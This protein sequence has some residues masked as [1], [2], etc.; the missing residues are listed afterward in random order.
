MGLLSNSAILG[1][2]GTI[3]AGDLALRDVPETSLDSG[4]AGRRDVQDLI[5][6]W[7]NCW[8]IQLSGSPALPGFLLRAYGMG[9]RLF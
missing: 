5:Y 6:R 9:Q 2:F 8:V 4:V 3:L 7:L 1:F